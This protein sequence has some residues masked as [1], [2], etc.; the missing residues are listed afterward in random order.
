[1]LV[2]EERRQRHAVAVVVLDEEHP[3][4]RGTLGRHTASSLSRARTRV[5]ARGPRSRLV[6]PWARPPYAL[7]CPPAM[8]TGMSGGPNSRCPMLNR[9]KVRIFFHCAAA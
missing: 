6:A 5:T 3:I 9:S 2:R 8:S 7:P 1:A 4:A